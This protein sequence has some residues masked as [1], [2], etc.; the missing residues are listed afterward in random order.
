MLTLALLQMSGIFILVPGAMALRSVATS[1]LSDGDASGGSGPV[2]LALTSRVLTV[3]VSIGA[4]LFMASL[5]LPPREMLHVRRKAH[6]AAQAAQGPA[7]RM[8]GGYTR[9]LSLAPVNM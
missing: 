5:I 1:L 3:A 9:M 6:Q 2:G 7:A 4:G 8:H